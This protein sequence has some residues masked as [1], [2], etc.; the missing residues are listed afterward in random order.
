MILA[1]SSQRAFI[2][3]LLIIKFLKVITSF[4]VFLFPHIWQLVRGLMEVP[5]K[6]DYRNQNTFFERMNTLF[7]F[8]TS[9]IQGN[10]NITEEFLPR[11]MRLWD[12]YNIPLSHHNTWPEGLQNGVFWLFYSST[13]N[14]SYGILPRQ[15]THAFQ[16]VLHDHQPYRLSAT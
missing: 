5:I 3:F 13:V 4:M 15:F 1:T 10:H 12:R 7:S 8:V 6:I 9:H 14:A 16:P 11:E 2:Y